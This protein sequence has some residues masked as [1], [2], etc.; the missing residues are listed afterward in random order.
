MTIAIVVVCFRIISSIIARVVAS[1]AIVGIAPTVGG[2]TP[3][4]GRIAPTVGGISPTVGG[5]SEG[6]THPPSGITPSHA[7]PP[8]EWA[9]SIPV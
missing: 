4:V 6:E 3:T 7:D 8:A 9:T 1:V 5:I 2:I